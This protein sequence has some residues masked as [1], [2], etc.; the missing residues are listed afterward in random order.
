[1]PV[2][3]HL[4]R[5]APDGRPVVVYD[6]KGLEH[7]AH[8]EFV[9]ETRAFLAS[10]Q[11]SLDVRNHIHL[12]W[13]VALLPAFLVTHALRLQVCGRFSTGSVPALRGG[14]MPIVARLHTPPNRTE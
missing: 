8:E 2:T 11:A 3:K 10:A 1:M 5:Y 7:G 13:C 6:T 12:A 9:R 14:D 4:A